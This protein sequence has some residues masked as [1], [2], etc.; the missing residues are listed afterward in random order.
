MTEEQHKICTRLFKAQEGI[1]FVEEILKPM[2]M[3]NYKDLL[4]SGKEFRDELVGFGNC[5]LTLLH[6]L[7][8]SDIRLTEQKRPLPEEASNWA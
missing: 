7:E 6:L 5:L 3:D 1:D 2:Q 4:N 8:N